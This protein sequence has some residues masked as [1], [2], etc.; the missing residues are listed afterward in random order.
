MTDPNSTTA[1]GGQS[2]ESAPQ[3]ARFPLERMLFALGFAFIAWVALWV[4]LFIGLVQWIVTAVSG[5]QDD[6][7]KGW[8]RNLN[9]Y[10]W[11]VL[12]FIVFAREDRPFPFGTPF[13]RM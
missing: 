4:V 7:L 12:S 5:T 11:E 13:P 1:D 8:G 9:Q 3:R 10:L 2:Q 6:T